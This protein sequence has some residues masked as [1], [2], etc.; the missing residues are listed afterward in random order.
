MD[1]FILSIFEQS[2]GILNSLKFESFSQEILVNSFCA[3]WI[4]R[5]IYVKMF[6]PQVHYLPFE[7]EIR[8]QKNGE[9]LPG[10]TRTLETQRSGPE[11]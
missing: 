7:K 10:L 2:T 9:F 1:K 3:E 8:F 11:S 5:C 6:N 4:E